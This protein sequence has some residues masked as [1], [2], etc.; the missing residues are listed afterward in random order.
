MITLGPR[1]AVVRHRHGV[2]A[3]APAPP[4]DEQDA[5]GAG[6]H[7]AGGTA[8][9]LARGTTIDEAVHEAAAGFVAGGAVRL[10]EGRW[11]QPTPATSGHPTAVTGLD[12]AL[13]DRARAT[14]GTVV[15]AGGSLDADDPRSVLDTLR[16]DLWVKGAD[17]DAADLPETPL[18]RAWG[19]EV[20]SVPYR[21]ERT[22]VPV[23]AA[24]S[25]GASDGTRLPSRP[26]R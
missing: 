17:H 12:S 7:F 18:V 24:K 21:P 3:A 8:A 10:V 16:P 13:A 1:G 5:C 11:V 4:V 22:V 9:A 20:I 6:D 2:C 19:G 23:P 26:P 25:S 14:G 15:A